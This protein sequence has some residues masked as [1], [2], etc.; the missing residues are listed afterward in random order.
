ML[1]L[2]SKV[3]PIN[4]EKS[5]KLIALRKTKIEELDKLYEIGAQEHAKPYLGTKTMGDYKREF[6]DSNTTYL[7]IV[8]TS[9]I[10]LGYIILSKKQSRSSIQ[11]KRILIGKENFGIGQNTLSRLE[12]YCL[13]TMG[14]KHIW[15]DVYDNN[16]KA[17]H[18]YEKLGY[19]LFDT[20]IQDNRKILFYD[21]SL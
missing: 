2:L 18:I 8:N 9:N 6:K 11:L 16:H 19:Q 20:K 17:I 7:S 3:K 5:L 10:I 12:Q 21:K 13:D 4:E 1:F 15:L 14:I